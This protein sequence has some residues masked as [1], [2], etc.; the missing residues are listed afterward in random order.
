MWHGVT[1]DII[2]ALGLAGTAVFMATNMNATAS[3]VLQVVFLTISKIGS[4]IFFSPFVA[5]QGDLLPKV[6]TNLPPRALP[7][8]A[9]RTCARTGL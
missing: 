2:A 1:G 4:S 8:A 3:S 6:P 5:F 7:S 9:R